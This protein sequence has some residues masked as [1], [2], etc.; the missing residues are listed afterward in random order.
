MPLKLGLGLKVNVPKEKTSL[1][2]QVPGQRLS[3]QSGKNEK[4][5]AHTEY[6]MKNPWEIKIKKEG[7]KT[8]FPIEGSLVT[9]HYC[10]YVIDREGNKDKEFESS[11]DK[12]EPYT[13]KV[14]LG[15]VI[16]GWDEAIPHISEGTEC[17]LIVRS[18]YAYGAR[19]IAN[20]L[21]PPSSDLRFE[22]E[23][24]KIEVKG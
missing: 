13:F 19:H 7:D 20:G 4:K 24:I 23:I 3:P 12:G 16:K 2:A 17:E 11:H 22:M 8:T 5:A 9:L 10:G 1:V 15:R 18:D 6:T 14:G 21:I